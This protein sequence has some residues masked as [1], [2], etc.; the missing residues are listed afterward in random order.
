MIP[1]P[2]QALPFNDSYGA[3]RPGVI[4][5]LG[6]LNIVIGALGGVVAAV[7]GFFTVIFI[8]VT[9]M[10]PM[11]MMHTGAPGGA[12]EIGGPNGFLI[13]DRTVIL[14][15][16]ANKQ[17][18]SQPQKDQLEFLLA[19]VGQK[20]IPAPAINP[21][22]VG[23]E[24]SADYLT[25]NLG[26]ATGMNN[27]GGVW[28]TVPIGTIT[29]TDTTATFTPGLGT[30]TP[31]LARTRYRSNPTPTSVTPLSPA[32]LQAVIDRV[33]EYAGASP[34]TPAQLNLLQ[35]QIQS[36]SATIIFPATD[37]AQLL[38]QV[39]A[40]TSL[41]NNTVMVAFTQGSIVLNPDGSATVTPGFN[42]H[43]SAG[44]AAGRVKSPSS[45]TIW[46]DAGLDVLLSIFLLT[47]GIITLRNS[48]VARKLMLIYVAAKVVITLLTSV[49]IWSM[50]QTF[51]SNMDAATAAQNSAAV[52]HV[53]MTMMVLAA[54]FGLGYP[55]L[56]LLLLW[57][58]SARAFYLVK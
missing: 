45:D 3:S 57:T 5:T 13:S 31:M 29:L 18:M 1:Q 38:G 58:R 12:T 41:G 2:V 17:G 25:Q 51:K 22:G 15:A 4:T 23:G 56:M 20:I 53:A 10:S 34:L 37:M 47:I 27:D 8:L 6:V 39:A 16:F 21:N 24:P 48:L 36:N 30:A 54:F 35:N 14:Q 7:S 19:D 52:D 28:Y 11:M 26:G 46:I 43:P 32:D 40:V 9:A 49:A 50:F 33:Q 44:V 55:L 42:P